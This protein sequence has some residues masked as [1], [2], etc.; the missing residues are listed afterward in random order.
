MIQI[1]DSSV[2]ISLFRQDE[3]L[4]EIAKDTFQS[5]NKFWV[6]D[7]VI[8]EVLTVLKIKEPPHVYQ[9]CEQFLTQNED[10]IIIYTD[11]PLF[12]QVQYF[13]VSNHNKLSFVD[14]LLLLK[15]KTENI[16]LLTFD[17]ELQKLTQTSL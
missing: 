10:I 4:H 8:A 11:P 7:H 9:Q 17:K 12:Q 3:P 14:A 2:I 5:G 13:F 15:S 1:L 6:L 16:P